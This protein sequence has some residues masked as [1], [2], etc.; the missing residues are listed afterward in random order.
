VVHQYRKLYGDPNIIKIKRC[1]GE[2]IN[3]AKEWENKVLNKLNV[4]END[5]WLNKSKNYFYTYHKT[6]WNTGLTKNT[7]KLLLRISKKIRNKKLGVKMSK[8][9]K[10][11]LKISSN[12]RKKENSWNQLK[13]N[14]T[15]YDKYES[16]NDFIN[17]L[18]LI[19]DDCWS[20]ASI[21]SN[22]MNVTVSGVTTALIHNNFTY[23]KDQKIAKVY[24]KYKHL[25][26]SYYD[27]VITILIM[28]LKGYTACQI[29]ESID[30]NSCGITTLIKS[31]S[32]I[33][34][35]SKRGP[36][37]PNF[38]QKLRADALEVMSTVYTLENNPLPNNI[39][40]NLRNTIS[41]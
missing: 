40:I 5:N 38:K 29:A 41:H 28:H 9:L 16:Y 1:F 30:V 26:N 31:Y 10:Y 22:K 12:N 21:I 17:E 11:K 15:L 20:I 14:S 24:S 35:K 25:F 33:P 2:N 27:Y 6:S 23:I 32:L 19:K 34:N 37:S 18:I 4:I 3:K 7:S 8:E 13:T 36:S 39:R